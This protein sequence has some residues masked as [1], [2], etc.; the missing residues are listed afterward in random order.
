MN[1]DDYKSKHKFF[2]KRATFSFIHEYL[3]VKP[4][5]PLKFVNLTSAAKVPLYYTA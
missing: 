3:T 2:S 4:V 1:K 5:A